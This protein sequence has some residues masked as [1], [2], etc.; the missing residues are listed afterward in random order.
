MKKIEIIRKEAEFTEII[1]KSPFKKNNYFVIYYKKNN[2]G[3]DRYGITVPKKTGKANIRN[4]IKRRTKSIIDSSEKK[5]QSSY[6]YVIITRKRL[7][8]VNYDI[9]E[10][11]LINLIIKIGEEDEKK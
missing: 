6:D 1:N 9:M 7:I 8:D 2:L 10:K 11:E 5:V 3:F 4:K